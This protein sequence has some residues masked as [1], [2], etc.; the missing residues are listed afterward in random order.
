MA[1]LLS[2]SVDGIDPNF[3]MEHQS[4]RTPLHAAAESGHVDICHMLI[5]VCLYL[6]V[7]LYE[8][9]SVFFGP[10]PHRT[11]A[12]L[13]NQCWKTSFTLL[14]AGGS[15]AEWCENFGDV[16]KDVFLGCFS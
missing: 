5:Q 7:F 16:T 4:K 9:F 8:Q 14:A 1:S 11:K 6:N 12:H 10:V 3:K 15:G 13:K 2:F